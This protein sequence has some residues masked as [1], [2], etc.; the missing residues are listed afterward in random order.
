[1]FHTWVLPVEIH[2]YKLAVGEKLSKHMPLPISPF[3]I[4]INNCCATEQVPNVKKSRPKKTTALD[5][6]NCTRSFMSSKMANLNRQCKYVWS[7]ILAFRKCHHFVCWFG[8]A[9]QMWY[10]KTQRQSNSFQV[11][12][13]TLHMPNSFIICIYSSQWMKNDSV[14][15]SRISDAIWTK[16]SG[17]QT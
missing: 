3:V 11:S 10:L 5:D 16:S 2:V 15:W 17:W 1:M 13:I 14:E 8:A 7:F 4:Q 9:F 12:S 6:P